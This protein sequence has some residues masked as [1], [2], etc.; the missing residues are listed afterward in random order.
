[1]DK[2]SLEGNLQFLLH[3]P[4]SMSRQ[5][6]SSSSFFGSRGGF[7]LITGDV[8]YHVGLPQQEIDVKILAQMLANSVSTNIY[9]YKR[10][11]H[12]S[13][14]A[15]CN[16]MVVFNQNLLPLFIFRGLRGRVVMGNSTITYI[17][18]T[19]VDQGNGSLN[20]NGGRSKRHQRPIGSKG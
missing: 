18:Q 16:C 20:A 19:R 4:P 6:T 15:L 7:V 11:F 3:L 17:H 8:D 5:V 13:Y 1:M 2:S 9:L 14:L 12:P 10:G